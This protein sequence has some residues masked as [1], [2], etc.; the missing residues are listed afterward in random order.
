MELKDFFKIKKFRDIRQDYLKNF[1]RE[2]FDVFG[3]MNVFSG[4]VPE[5]ITK[6]LINQL[7]FL[8]KKFIEYSS[9][10][11]ETPINDTFF[12]KRMKQLKRFPVFEKP[13]VLCKP[14][15]IID[16]EG[17]VKIIDFNVS[18]AMT[19]FDQ[20][21]QMIRYYNFKG[22]YLSRKMEYL[23]IIVKYFKEQKKPVII[24]DLLNAETYRGKFLTSFLQSRDL[25]V[26]Y[27]RLGIDRI[28][29]I[30]R[31][32]LLFKNFH[33]TRIFENLKMI[34]LLIDYQEKYKFLF[35]FSPLA[36]LKL[37]NRLVYRDFFE[38]NKNLKKYWIKTYIF[39]DFF[40]C[41]NLYK[42]DKFILRS[43]NPALLENKV[44]I[45]NYPDK[46]QIEKIKKDK[47]C[48]DH[49][50]VQKFYPIRKKLVYCVANEG[51]HMESASGSYQS[52]VIDGDI[53]ETIV[54]YDILKHRL[55]NSKQI[56]N[57]G[58]VEQGDYES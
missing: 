38:N 43:R 7:K 22:L 5:K 35:V 3:E 56:I 44:V 53:C 33:I 54:C 40:S 41:W 11:L 28:E 4:V 27:F 46:L 6:N 51:I 13:L 25:E 15:W 31:N 8:I 52:Y 47:T 48:L 29:N 1:N 2:K 12:T 21:H 32:C 58:F 57:L 23:E 10:R 55:E 30:P 34:Q 24:L 39:D 20:C 17:S 9:D 49:Y 36:E 42:D 18:N 14:E 37:N 26:Y 45:L 50:I 19:H 16:D